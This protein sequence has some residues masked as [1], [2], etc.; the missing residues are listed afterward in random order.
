MSTAVCAFGGND[1]FDPFAEADE[2]S[3]AKSDLNS[4]KDS[5]SEAEYRQNVDRVL[6]LTKNFQ[7]MSRYL[8]MM[9]HH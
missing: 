9:E 2:S 1:D 5:K 4:F 3:S 7:D 8:E 6:K